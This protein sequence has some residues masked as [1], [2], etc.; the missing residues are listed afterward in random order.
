VPISATAR[1]NVKRQQRSTF[2]VKKL[3]RGASCVHVS[4]AKIH[5]CC[6][7]AKRHEQAYKYHS[8]SYYASSFG[9]SLFLFSI[10]FP[11]KIRVGEIIFRILQTPVLYYLSRCEF[12]QWKT[13]QMFH[14][15][16]Y[17]KWKINNRRNKYINTQYNNIMLL[18][19]H[20]KLFYKNRL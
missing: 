19:S 11:S 5:A 8:F 6:R 20:K 15:F 1:R 14:E 10:L 17:L 3:L 4:A 13:A 7:F 9:T 2:G 16:L 18:C 12:Q